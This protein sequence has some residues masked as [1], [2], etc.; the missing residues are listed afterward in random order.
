MVF[1]GTKSKH[2]QTIEQNSYQKSQ[3]VASISPEPSDEHSLKPDHKHSLK[4]DHPKPPIHEVGAIMWIPFAILAI[5]TVFIGLIGF[6]FEEE[7][8][9][10]MAS[11]LSSSFGIGEP[12]SA[13]NIDQ[14]ADRNNL[15]IK[16]YC[17]S[18]IISSFWYRVLVGNII[19]YY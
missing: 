4:Q 10:I 6:I 13:N 14:N 19:L 5:S 2:I 12:V 15:S 1:F 9:S 7:I 3:S 8:H 11:Y 17:S 18:F 16:P